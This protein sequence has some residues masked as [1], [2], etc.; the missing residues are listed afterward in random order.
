MTVHSDIGFD[1]FLEFLFGTEESEYEEE[2][3]QEEL[4]SGCDY[5][6]LEA[7]GI[8][9]DSDGGREGEASAEFTV[10]SGGKSGGTVLLEIY[11]RNTEELL[12]PPNKSCQNAVSKAFKK[13]IPSSKKTRKVFHR[14][15]PVITRSIRK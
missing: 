11:V 9:S 2:E 6:A 10:T 14:Q 12:N 13:A 7:I 3:A 15:A 8:D 5:E 4:D 1:P